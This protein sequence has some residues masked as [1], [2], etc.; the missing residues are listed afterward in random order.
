[1]ATT[2][3][4]FDSRGIDCKSRIGLKKT[5]GEC[6]YHVITG[7]APVFSTIRNYLLLFLEFSVHKP[8]WYIS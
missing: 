8:K 1:M 2:S 4:L 6:I 5:T 3:L 7:F